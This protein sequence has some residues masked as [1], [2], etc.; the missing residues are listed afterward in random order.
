MYRLLV[1]IYLNTIQGYF[2]FTQKKY[3]LAVVYY[4]ESALLG[5]DIAETNA[6]LLINNYQVF[7]DDDLDAAGLKDK[8]TQ[9]PIWQA[10]AATNY[11]KPPKNI[12]EFLYEDFLELFNTLQYPQNKKEELIEK[13]K[14]L[15]E[16]AGK[17]YNEFTMIEL[18]RSGT[19][20]YEPLALVRLAD[21]YQEGRGVPQNY[22]Q[23]YE[24]L[25]L[26]VTHKIGQVTHLL[27]SHAYYNLA[28]MN[29]YGLGREKDLVKA[30]NLYN[31]SL[32]VDKTNY[33]LVMIN[34]KLAEL[35]LAYTERFT[36]GTEENG[37]K[38]PPVNLTFAD[39]VKLNV[40]HFEEHYSKGILVG[41]LGLAVF[42]LC[43]VRLRLTNYIDIYLKGD[44]SRQEG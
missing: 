11:H 15:P 41:F 23:A 21:M 39:I 27:L 31:A 20:Q 13:L 4:M 12:N 10:L 22:T 25:K 5:Y 3:K 16:E 43:L 18:L 24:Y 34:K 35:E 32:E 33:Y 30:I 1:I 14:A 2:A 38:S 9:D 40:A 19:S 26:L 8:I 44:G 42:V 6:A 17:L 37:E 7:K 28:Y 29:H 36:E